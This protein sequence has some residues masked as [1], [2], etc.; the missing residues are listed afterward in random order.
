MGEMLGCDLSRCAVG[1]AAALQ[2]SLEEGR[3]ELGSV[4]GG[5]YFRTVGGWDERRYSNALFY[6]EALA[7]QSTLKEEL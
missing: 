4:H 6:E 7:L 3:D 1:R 5:F 2:G